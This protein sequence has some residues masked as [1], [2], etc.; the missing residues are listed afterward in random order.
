MNAKQSVLQKI[1]DGTFALLTDEEIAKRLKL[2]RKESLGLRDILRALVREGELLSDSRYRDGTA[3]QFGAKRGTFSGNERGFGFFI[4]EDGSGDLFIPRRAVKNA[5][6]GDTVLCIPVRGR[7]DDE[8]EILAVLS[9]GYTELVGT[10]RREGKIG[11]L[12]PDERKYTRD[13]LILPGKTNN[14]PPESKAVAKITSFRPDN[15]PVGEIKEVLGEKGDFFAEELSLIRAHHLYETFP[16]DVLEEA[17]K[18]EDRFF[19]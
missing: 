11:Y 5:L 9:R 4:P 15:T 8:G 12:H 14:C 18:Q 10:F 2:G 7:S 1:K 17:K 6:H 13:I 3:E 16:E 19:D